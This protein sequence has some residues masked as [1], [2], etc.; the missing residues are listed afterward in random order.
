MEF[1]Q[2]GFGVESTTSRPAKTSEPELTMIAG[3]SGKFKL[4]EA[5]S[6]LLGVKPGDY[7]VFVSNRNEVQQA[8]AENHP[9]LVEWAE[10]NDANIK[11]Y[12]VTW[13]IAKGWAEKDKDGNYLKTR[14]PLTKVERERLI[15]E[16]NVDD[17]GHAIAPEMNRYKGSRLSSKSPEAR[18]GMIVEGTDGNNWPVLREGVPEDKHAVYSISKEGSTIEVPNGPDTEEVD[19]YSISFAREEDKIKRGE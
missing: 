3:V 9:A 15:E 16:G 8:I 14:K 5:A 7:I 2:F 12:P 18:V 1:P 10:E 6:T 13:G 4:N 19:I 11:D 17:E